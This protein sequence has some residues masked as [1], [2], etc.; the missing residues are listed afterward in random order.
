MIPNDPALLAY[1]VSFLRSLWQC[2]R[3]LIDLILDAGGVRESWAQA[4]AFLAAR[5]SD[6]PMREFFCNRTVPGYARSPRDGSPDWSYWR[7]DHAPLMVAEVK[8]LAGNHQPKVFGGETVSPN[9]FCG[10]HARYPLAIDGTH[11][12]LRGTQLGWGLLGD[13]VRLRSYAGKAPLR[14]MVLILDK[15]RVQSRLGY[16]LDRVEF[17]GRGEVVLETPLWRC[18]AWRIRKAE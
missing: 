13:Y 11:P 14:M 3:H 4:D 10:E 16:C 5:T 8:L 2:R 17:D 9:D 6:P 1:W 12:I 7:D 15:R 18:K